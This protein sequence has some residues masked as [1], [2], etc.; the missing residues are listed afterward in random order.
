[1]DTPHSSCVNLNYLRL[2]VGNDPATVRSILTSLVA[3]L[4]IELD[5]VVALCEAEH[6]DEL[7][8]ASHKLKSSLA[9]VGNEQMTAAND[10]LERLAG[11]RSELHRAPGLVRDLAARLPSIVRAIEKEIDSG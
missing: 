3:R 10:E 1:M 5:E 7:T 6:W 4:S 2:M 11:S 9:F 8:L